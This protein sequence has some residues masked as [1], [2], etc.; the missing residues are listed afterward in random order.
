M[1]Y[2]LLY[3]KRDFYSVVTLYDSQATLDNLQA[4][5]Y[6]LHILF[7]TLSILFT[8]LAHEKCEQNRP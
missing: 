4:T 6:D 5:L 1:I 8:I 3:A 2:R 7:F